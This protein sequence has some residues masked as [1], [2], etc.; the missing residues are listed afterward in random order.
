[1]KCS[2]CGK[3]SCHKNDLDNAPTDCPSLS[4]AKDYVTHAYNAEDLRIAKN[5]ALV[6]SIGYGKNTRV[7]EI[8][9]F[10]QK[11]GYQKLGLAFCMGLHQEAKVFTKILQSNSFQVE[12]IICKNGGF[13]KNAIGIAEPEKICRGGFEAMCNPVG[14]A[15]HLQQAG[16]DFNIILGL[17]VGHDTLFMKYSHAPVTVLAVKDRV[18]AHNPLAAI[19]QADAYYKRLYTFIK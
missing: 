6:E 3:H 15:A 9:D 19:Y 14:Q 1:M 4:M 11:C 17:C 18:L 10:A 13:D 12:S 16:T 8:M 5:A 2:L 7:E